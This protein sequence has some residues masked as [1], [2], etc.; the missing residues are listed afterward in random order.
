MLLL[1][2]PSRGRGLKYK[3]S[4]FFSRFRSVAPS[5]N[6][7]FHEPTAVNKEQTSLFGWKVICQF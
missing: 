4:K 1:S 6:V 3:N 7:I 5:Q 2:L